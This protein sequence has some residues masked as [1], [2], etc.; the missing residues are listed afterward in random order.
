MSIE[1]AVW[2]QVDELNNEISVMIKKSKSFREINNL[3]KIKLELNEISDLFL[4]EEYRR[5]IDNAIL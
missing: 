4:Y 1:N 5:K 2:K 3:I